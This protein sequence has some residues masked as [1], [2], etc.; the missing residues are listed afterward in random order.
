VRAEPDEP[1][2][3]A[4]GDRAFSLR[5]N[6]LA[7]FVGR[8]S[9]DFEWLFLPHHALVVS[10][11]LTLARDRGTLPAYATGFAGDRATGVGVELGYH[12]FMTGTSAPEG[13]FFGPSLLLDSTRPAPNVDR[14][15]S[16]GLAFDVGY[17]AIVGPGF[18]MSAGG[19][20]LAIG[21]SGQSLKLSPRLLF[22]VGWT[23]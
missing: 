11:H 7:L 20:L 5:F 17:Q 6:P 4:R 10:P 21:T 19:G 12:H 14:F 16:Y 23:F 8:A 1:E 9:V 13:V 15:T 22:G 3:P 2:E 18:T